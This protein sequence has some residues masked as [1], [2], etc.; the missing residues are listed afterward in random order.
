MID[1]SE[2]LCSPLAAGFQL[3]LYYFCL[4]ASDAWDVYGDDVYA[5][6]A[7]NIIALVLA[8]FC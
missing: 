7:A 3:F 5:A 8:F 4:H 1:R 6:F 2:T